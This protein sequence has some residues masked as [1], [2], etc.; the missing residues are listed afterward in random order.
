MSDDCMR[1]PYG[2]VAA[3]QVGCQRLAVLVRQDASGHRATAGQ[4]VGWQ[5]AWRLA[6]AKAIE[7]Q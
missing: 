7:Q 3:R 2:K 1:V 6:T 4:M 5:Y